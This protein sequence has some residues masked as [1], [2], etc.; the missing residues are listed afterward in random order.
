[1][2]ATTTPTAT[3]SLWKETVEKKEKMVSSRYVDTPTR[4]EGIGVQHI[5]VFAQQ[6]EQQK[7]GEN[8]RKRV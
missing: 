7:R 8:K 4:D 3:L 5:V 6:Y 2:M 1:M